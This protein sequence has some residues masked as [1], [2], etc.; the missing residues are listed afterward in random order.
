[1]D[2]GLVLAVVA[3]A[4]AVAYVSLVI[5]TRTQDIRRS[6]NRRLQDLQTSRDVMDRSIVDRALLPTFRRIGALGLRITPQQW[7]DRTRSR[8]IRA[9]WY[10]TIDEPSWAAVR[11]V[12]LVLGIVAFF[13]FS[14]FVSPGIQ[15]IALLTI[16]LLGG[17]AGPDQILNRRAADRARSIERDLP[18]IIDLL[19]ISIEAGMGFEAAL[20]RV[21]THVPGELS[22]EFGRMLQETR[23]GV[24]RHEAMLS[25]AERTDV[26]DLNSFVLAMNQ[27]DAFGVSVGRMLRVQ[28]DEMR[29][30][31]RQRAQERA[32]A[33]PVKMVFPLVFCIFPSIFVVLLGPAAL[34]IFE[35]LVD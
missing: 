13:Y 1:M 31:R 26:D 34:N 14:Q 25:L 4:V 21:V 17:Y 32:F 9:A 20:G 29:V 8:L 19:V 22:E 35:N 3:V 28:A 6:V 24:S 33:A 30:R 16:C 23:V 12:S 11:V 2:V 7:A 27:A 18:D 10:P 15:T 5:G